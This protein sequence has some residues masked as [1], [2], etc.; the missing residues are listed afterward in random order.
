MWQVL[1]RLE[2]E[3]ALSLRHCLISDTAT[4]EQRSYGVTAAMLQTQRQISDKKRL[5]LATA[6]ALE[7]AGL[8][9]EQARRA[10]VY[11]VD[12]SKT[13]EW[14]RVSTDS[15]ALESTFNLIRPTEI[16]TRPIP[17]RHSPDLD[18]YVALDP[19]PRPVRA[20]RLGQRGRRPGCRQRPDYPAHGA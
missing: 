18:L 12:L 5:R 15:V 16:G 13:V 3:G 4:A 14:T 10:G 11:C 8:P 19:A 17:L 6:A 1:A 9:R 2:R 20:V 7:A